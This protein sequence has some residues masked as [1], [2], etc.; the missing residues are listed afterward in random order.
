MA[1]L[2]FV[3]RLPANQQ[4]LGSTGDLVD[5]LFGSERTALKALVGGLRDIQHGECFYC[6]TRMPDTV[7]VDHF[8]PWSRYPRDL[9]HNF[10]LAH[11][12]CN[13]DKRDMLAAPVHLERWVQRN[14][15]HRGALQKILDE[16][17]FM[18]DL[19]ASLTIAE[20]RAA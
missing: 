18:Y 10:V 8:I 9:G 19:D 5:F 16:A 3:Q 12:S 14:D 7:A 15:S 6:R 13:L 17:R 11:D 2:T 1:W 4:V 20:W